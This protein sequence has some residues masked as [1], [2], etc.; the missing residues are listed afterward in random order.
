MHPHSISSIRR[1][2]TLGTPVILAGLVAGIA[3][4][5]GCIATPT[6]SL[7]RMNK[8]V[9]YGQMAIDD[10]QIVVATNGPVDID[11]DSFGGTV[12]VEAVPGLKNTIIE[13]VRHANHGHLRRDEA[14]ASLDQMDYVVELIPGDLNRE[15]VRVIATSDD[16]EEHFQGVDFR[17]R[18]ADLGSVRVRTDHGRVW[19]KN[20]KG[21]VDVETTHGDIRVITDHPMNEPIILVTKEGD[22]DY[23]APKGSTGIY[24]LRSIGGLVYNRFTE[25]RVVSTSPE[26]DPATFVADVGGG[27]NPVL[28]RTTYGDIRVAVTEFP[29]G[30][31]PIIME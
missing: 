12:L 17:I 22:V 29:T 27:L 8:A 15:T 31:G 13:P 1:L 2:S 18:T 4:L 30:V 28:V 26:N 19:V 25:A 5:Q 23:R 21:G 6:S 24:D 7:E 20:N 16:L 10:P 14:E 9:V 11:I 3:T